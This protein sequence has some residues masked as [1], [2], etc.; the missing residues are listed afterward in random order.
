M[1]R[2]SDESKTPAYTL[3]SA[4]TLVL[5]ALSGPLNRDAA[6]DPEAVREEIGDKA[7][8]TRETLKPLCINAWSITFAI[9]SR[10]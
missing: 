7:L 8:V 4:E 6:G 5:R 9:N 2:L 1:R 3:A 10:P